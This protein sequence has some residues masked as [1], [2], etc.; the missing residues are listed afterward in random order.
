LFRVEIWERHVTDILPQFFVQKF[1]ATKGEFLVMKFKIDGPR[2]SSAPLRQIVVE[3]R[4]N[5]T[6]FLF[7]PEV[8]NTPQARNRFVR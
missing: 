7:F 3:R 4:V 8:K 5:N 1:D 2:L 6:D